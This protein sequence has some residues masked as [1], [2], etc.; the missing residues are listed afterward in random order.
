MPT[1]LIYPSM[2]QADGFFRWGVGGAMRVG[3]WDGSDGWVKKQVI[4]NGGYLPPF[5]T[6]CL[7]TIPQ[8]EVD[9]ERRAG[10]EGEGGG[11]RATGRVGDMRLGLGRGRAWEV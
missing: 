3:G 10:M 9:L 2:P 8:V 6:R 7:P 1:L 5:P 4:Q 11:M